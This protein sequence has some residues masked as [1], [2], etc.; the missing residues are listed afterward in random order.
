M[1]RA[2]VQREAARLVCKLEG[3]GEGEFEAFGARAFVRLNLAPSSLTAAAVPGVAW[4]PRAA[5]GGAGMR[6]AS[7]CARRS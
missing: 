4:R 7:S 1:R 6:L 2:A 3:W 5:G